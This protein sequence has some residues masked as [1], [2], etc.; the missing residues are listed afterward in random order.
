MGAGER[1]SPSASHRKTIADSD[2]LSITTQLMP[3]D[4]KGIGA[5]SIE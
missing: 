3:W 4:E 1:G 2:P 5:N